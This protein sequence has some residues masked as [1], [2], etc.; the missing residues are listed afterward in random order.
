LD[1]RKTSGSVFAYSTIGI[2][3]AA[4]VTLFV[5]GGYKLDEYKQTTPVF[6]IIGAFLGM[7]IGFINLLRQLQTMERHEKKEINKQ[8]NK[9]L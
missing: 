5:L 8:R 3:L 6:T 9:W 1:K 7:V 2:Q 4:T